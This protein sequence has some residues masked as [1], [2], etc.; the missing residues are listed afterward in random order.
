MDGDGDRVVHKWGRGNPG[1]HD[2]EKILI[3]VCGGRWR[4]RRVARV[5]TPDLP[6]T[7][8]SHA[9][10]IA[11]RLMTRDWVRLPADVSPPVTYGQR[12]GRLSRRA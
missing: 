5:N 11:M 2:Y 9:I 6:A 4:V 8:E 10:Q 3:V 12:P 1:G 7:S